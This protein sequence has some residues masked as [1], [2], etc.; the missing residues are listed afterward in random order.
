MQPQTLGTTRQDGDKPN[1]GSVT[2]TNPEGPLADGNEP[3][4]LAA[5][6]GR[7]IPRF[8]DSA[9]NDGRSISAFGFAREDDA[10]SCYLL[11][12]A[13]AEET[14]ALA[15]DHGADGRGTGETRFAFAIVNTEPL[16]EPAGLA[17]RVAI[18]AESGAAAA[19]R[20]A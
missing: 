18:A 5:R 12:A 4:L 16:R 20:L 17:L 13:R 14:R 9:L 1:V 3:S 11:L 19:D 6:G 15:D 8:E 2:W 10:V 7:E